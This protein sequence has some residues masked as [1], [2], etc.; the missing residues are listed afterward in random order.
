MK[1]SLP[2]K[3]WR[4]WVASNSKWKIFSNF[5]ASSEYPNFNMQCQHFLEITGFLAHQRRLTTS[6]FWFLVENSILKI[7]GSLDVKIT[8]DFC[9]W[10]VNS[11]WISLCE[12]LLG[13]NINCLELNQFQDRFLCRQK[14]SIFS[15][16]FTKTLEWIPKATSIRPKLIMVYKIKQRLKRLWISKAAHRK[17]LMTALFFSQFE[18]WLNDQ[19]NDI[20]KAKLF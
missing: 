10:N 5:V 13:C 1:K 9:S 16:R 19:K 3:I 7:F 6:Y 11:F 12:V 20:I 8:P 18:M 17:T 15:T 2:L 14:S 4:Y